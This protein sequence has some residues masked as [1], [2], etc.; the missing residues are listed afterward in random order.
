[1]KELIEITYVSKTF[2]RVWFLTN[3]IR[4]YSWSS[5]FHPLSPLQ[6]IF[7]FCCMMIT[8]CPSINS[9]TFHFFL[10]FSLAL[11]LQEGLYS[12]H[13]HYF[14]FCIPSGSLFSLDPTFFSTYFS[15][16]SQHQIQKSC[17]PVLSQHSL[18]FSLDPVCQLPTSWKSFSGSWTHPTM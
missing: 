14:L 17:I 1:M 3:G 8:E 11:S 10:E 7:F 2:S 13:F 4:S 16:L 12:Q 15:L 6:A 5:L 18:S 9:W